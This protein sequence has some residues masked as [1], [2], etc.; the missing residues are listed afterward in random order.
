MSVKIYWM[1]GC[2]PCNAT[3]KWLTNNGVEFEAVELK[4]IEDIEQN[5]HPL[6]YRSVPVAVTQNGAWGYHEGL[7]ALKEKLA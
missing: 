7:K 2:Q 3:K 1:Q 4:T 6:G 5:I